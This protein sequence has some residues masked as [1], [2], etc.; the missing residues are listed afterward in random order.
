MA[1]EDLTTYTESDALN[2]LTETASRVTWAG[3]DRVDADIYLY[4]DY[5]LDYFDG[6]FA[7]YLTVRQDAGGAFCAAWG[8]TNA[9]GGV[10]PH[11]WNDLD[12]LMVYFTGAK[13]K[14]WEISGTVNNFSNDYDIT[15]GIT[16][17]LTIVRD[18][19]GGVGYG[20]LKTF[21][22]SDSGRTT[23]LATLSLNLQQSKKDFR[24]VQLATSYG[25]GGGTP[26]D[27]YAEDLDL[28]AVIAVTPTV[29]T[30][31]VTNIGETTATANGNITDL[32]SPNPTAHGF[33]YSPTDTTPDIE[34]DSVT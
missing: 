12:M 26:V 27:G 2:R 10:V 16:Y 22:Y 17:Y 19:A 20:T 5:G 31:A 23:L 15:N 21:I 4:K 24:Y 8:L 9:L 3:L 29:T 32:G 18:E 30:Q 33:A 6:D 7:H 11:E 25:I 34:T 1:T 28:S 14:M 13:L